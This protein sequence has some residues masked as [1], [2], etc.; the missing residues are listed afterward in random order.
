MELHPAAEGLSLLASQAFPIIFWR[1]YGHILQ[2]RPPSRA[3]RVSSLPERTQYPILP[4]LCEGRQL[5]TQLA[6]EQHLFHHIMGKNAHHTNR[7]VKSTQTSTSAN[8]LQ[9]TKYGCDVGLTQ[10]SGKPQAKIEGISIPAIAY[11]TTEM[12]G[13]TTLLSKGARQL[14]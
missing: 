3:Q 12:L 5:E 13:R 8:R 14:V 10:H 7:G 11:G 6:A 1:R 4:G 9:S 2:G